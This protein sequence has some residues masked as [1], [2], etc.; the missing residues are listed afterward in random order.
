MGFSILAASSSQAATTNNSKVLKVFLGQEIDSLNPFIA[1][2]QSS[3]GVGVVQYESLVAYAAKDNAVV[4][5]IA[6]KW[7][8]SADGLT[9]TF[10]IPKGRVWSDGKPLTSKDVA[11]TYNAIMTNKKLQAANGGLVTNIKSVTADGDNK[12]AFVLKSPQAANPGAEIP[13]VP[14]HV[15]GKLPNPDKFANDKNDVGSGPFVVKS[16]NQGQSVQMVANKHFWRGVPKA[17]GLTFIYYKN[18]DAAVQALKTGELDVVNRLEPAQFDALKGQKHITTNA[19]TGRRYQA[20]ALNP[21]AKDATGAPLGD[22]NPAL[23]DPVLRT[24]IFRAIDSKTLLAKVIQGEGTLGQ[25]EVPP[26]YPAYFGID[27]ADAAKHSFDPAAAN[28]M[29]DEAGYKKGSNGIRLDKKGK[30]L[31][32]RLMG[33][34]S[35]ATHAQMADYVKPWLKAIGIGVKTTMTSDDRVNVDST[36][37]KY[38]MYFTGW[39]LGPDPDFQ[40]SINTCDSFPNKDGSGALSE[41]NWCSP[42]FDKLFKAQHTELDKTKRAE[43]VKQAFATLYNASV[44]DVLY[45]RKNLEAYRSDRWGGFAKQPAGSGSIME[46]NGYWGYYSAT[47]ASASSDSDSGGFPAWATILIVVVVVGAVG[48]VVVARRRGASADDRE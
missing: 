38:D 47:P 29:L 42:E 24:A 45:Y 11:W 31:N 26:V 37:G 19:G 30:P 32:L 28:K 44:S 33:R 1:I 27:D 34:T 35:D 5:G 23:K 21:G 41:N 48:G 9:W 20:L 14:E 8:T 25:T 13:I 43:L 2:F 6:S 16:Y 15:W 17:S 46:Q 39:G 3:T 22:G 12:V 18:T 4:P 36:V 40:L 10:D 7:T